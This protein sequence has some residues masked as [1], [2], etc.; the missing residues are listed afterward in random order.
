MNFEAF[1]LLA[2]CAA[3]SLKAQTSLF[4]ETLNIICTYSVHYT[5]LLEHA[6]WQPSIGSY[7]IQCA[8]FSFSRIIPPPINLIKLNCT[9]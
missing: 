6:Q 3:G 4:P 2:V 9:K 1:T 7:D 5:L 8:L